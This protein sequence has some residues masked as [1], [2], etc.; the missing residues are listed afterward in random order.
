LLLAFVATLSQCL[1]E[2]EYLAKAGVAYILCQLAMRKLGG[3]HMRECYGNP[4]SKPTTGGVALAQC[5]A[6]SG[7]PTRILIT[8]VAKTLNESER[9]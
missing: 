7:R 4:D 2:L 6:R 5:D 1:M 9:G 3:M 8:S